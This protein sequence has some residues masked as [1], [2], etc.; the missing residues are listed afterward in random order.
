MRFS[1]R[2]A[3]ISALAASLAGP[4]CALT[5][6]QVETRNYTAEQLTT[7]SE[8]LSGEEQAGKRTYLRTDPS[9][10]AGRYFIADLDSPLSAL[11]KGSTAVLEIIRASDG[12]T[13][14]ISLPFSEAIGSMGTALYI[15]LT[16][17][18]SDET[19]LAW[20]LT[21]RDASDK[22]LAEKHSY[23]WEMPSE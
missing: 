23:L 3:L 9:I 15:G 13:R 5:I 22:V 16:G 10:K 12:T 18:N 20:R 17:E 19:M 21:M 4:L 2:I 8:I 1:S 6:K 11:P 7:V 14:T